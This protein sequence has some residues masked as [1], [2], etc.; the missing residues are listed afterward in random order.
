MPGAAF[1]GLSTAP[2]AIPGA[3]AS[4]FMGEVSAESLLWLPIGRA[5]GARGAVLGPRLSLQS[6]YF[7]YRL[8]ARGAHAERCL[9]HVLSLQS[10]Y[11]GYRLVALGRTRSGAWSTSVTAES[12]LWLPI[13]RAWGA[14]GAV[15]GPHRSAVHFKGEVRPRRR[16]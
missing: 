3:A 1:R 7:G 8:V 11:F 6:R 2:R 12:L 9:V 13:G 15:L 4:N 10:R 14:R 5:W 16:L